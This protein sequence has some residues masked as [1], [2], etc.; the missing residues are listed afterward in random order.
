MASKTTYSCD[1]CDKDIPTIDGA[2]SQS[3][4]V[5]GYTMDITVA[6]HGFIGG[7]STCGFDQSYG[8]ILLCRACYCS[9]LA[10]LNSVLPKKLANL[11]QRSKD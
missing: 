10:K 5:H 11:S 1:Q 3:S 6:E 4:Q 2:I 7:G 9:L 8:S